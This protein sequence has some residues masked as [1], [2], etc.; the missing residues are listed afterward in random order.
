MPTRRPI[1]K[2]PKCAKLSISDTEFK[3]IRGI[4]VIKLTW[5]ESD[6]DTNDQVDS[7]ED[8]LRDPQSNPSS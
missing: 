1:R 7:Q 5:D 6:G 2:P 4:V 3:L 8:Q